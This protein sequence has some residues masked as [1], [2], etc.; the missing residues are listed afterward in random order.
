MTKEKK[1]WHY[2]INGHRNNIKLKE[3]YFSE[4]PFRMKHS[5][6]VTVVNDSIMWQVVVTCKNHSLFFVI[7]I[8]SVFILET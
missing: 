8:R 6:Y 2:Y 3:K 1:Q 4:V 7:G 5:H